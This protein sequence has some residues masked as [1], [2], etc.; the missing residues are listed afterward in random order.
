MALRWIY[1]FTAFALFSLSGE[2]VAFGQSYG[3]RNL[4][5][6]GLSSTTSG[7]SRSQLLHFQNDLGDQYLLYEENTSA[8]GVREIAGLL[9]FLGH[10]DY[11]CSIDLDC[12][13]KAFCTGDCKKLYYEIFNTSAPSGRNACTIKAFSCS[14]GGV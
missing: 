1:T 12:T 10:A 8:G 5:P 13:T 14:Q 3:L 9:P 11:V 2:C 6:I 7:A 4:R